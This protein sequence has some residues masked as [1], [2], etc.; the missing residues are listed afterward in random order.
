MFCGLDRIVATGKLDYQFQHDF[1]LSSQK[2]V[3][4]H[5]FCQQNV[6]QK[7]QNG[8]FSD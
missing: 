1:N 6:R 7:G 4:L 2:N 8:S 5:G 3:P